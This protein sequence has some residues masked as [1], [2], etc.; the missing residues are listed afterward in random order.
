MKN[1]GDLKTWSY[2]ELLREERKWGK[3]AMQ[4]EEYRFEIERRYQNWKVLTLGI[5][6]SGT[7][8]AAVFTILNYLLSK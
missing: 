7:I 2:W 3:H 5:T 4:A 8:I 1:K 6:A